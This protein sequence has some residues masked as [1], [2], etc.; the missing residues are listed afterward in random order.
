MKMRLMYEEMLSI[1][2]KYLDN[3]HEASDYLISIFA[4]IY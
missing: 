2:K 1:R 3:K 4:N